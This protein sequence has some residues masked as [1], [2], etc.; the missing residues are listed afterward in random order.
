MTHRD[1]ALITAAAA[2]L[3]LGVSSAAV[4][5][6]VTPEVIAPGAGL[7]AGSIG[8]LSPQNVPL[9]PGSAAPSSEQIGP[10]GIRLAP[11]GTVG[12][13]GVPLVTTPAEPR[14]P[15]RRVR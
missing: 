13:A 14:A 1:F 2:G 5:Q 15:G 3:L 9:A 6:T 11:G 12:N 7:S 10:G 4:A 8:G